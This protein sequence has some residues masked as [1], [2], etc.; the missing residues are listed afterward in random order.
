MS[1]TYMYEIIYVLDYLK[2][3]ISWIDTHIHTPPP[4]A[5]T[6]FRD[7]SWHSIAAESVVAI[8]VLF[9]QLPCQEAGGHQS[10][11]SV[12]MCSGTSICRP[13]PRRKLTGWVKSLWCL[14]WEL[15]S[16]GSHGETPWLWHLTRPPPYWPPCPCLCVWLTLPLSGLW[17]LNASSCEIW[18]AF[19]QG[20]HWVTP[21]ETLGFWG[22]QG[23]LYFSSCRF[24][25][26]NADGVALDQRWT[27]SLSKLGWEWEPL[28]HW[29][30]WRS[31]H[32]GGDRPD[33]RAP[34]RSGWPRANAQWQ[35]GQQG[36]QSLWE[37]QEGGRVGNSVHFHGTTAILP[38][39]GE[40][41]I[42]DIRWVRSTSVCMNQQF[43]QDCQFVRNVGRFCWEAIAEIKGNNVRESSAVER[44]WFEV[45]QPWDW[46]VSFGFSEWLVLI[47]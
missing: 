13:G 33:C 40:E 41:T 35:N 7:H 6:Y 17:G 42:P 16:A 12:K 29:A 46:D 3:E 10:G 22:F 27:V 11:N 9:C 31:Q 28:G 15:V 24:L 2:Y 4:H 26:G 36:Y 14:R 47:F 23:G 34:S 44:A 1:F 45:G 5:H 32:P 20:F 30:K 18:C 21:S 43:L 25:P 38:K 8:L 39:D 19:P 37:V